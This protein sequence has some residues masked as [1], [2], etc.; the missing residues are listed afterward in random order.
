MAGSATL[1]RQDGRFLIGRRTANVAR[2][3]NGAL[4]LQISSAY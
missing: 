4:A 2:W 1:A 3:Q